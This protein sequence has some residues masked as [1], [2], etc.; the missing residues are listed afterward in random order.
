MIWYNLHSMAIR[1]AFKLRYGWRPLG[2][3]AALLEE[4]QW[5]PWS[6][7]EAL[8]MRKLKAL[9]EHA[10]AH[11]P[12]YQRRFDE[13]GVR[14]DHIQ[15]PQDLAGLPILTKRHIQEHLDELLAQGVDK[16][17][18]LESRTGGST[19]HPLTFYQDR[20][21]EAWLLADLLR[22]NRMG[23]YQL[24]MRW[25][26]LWGS[27]YDAQP[28]KGWRGFVRDRLIYNALWINTFDLT[29]DTLLHAV[30]QLVRWQP[31]II[32]AYVSSATLLARL[33]QEKGITGI[34]PQAIQTSAEVLTPEDRCLLEEA[35]AC[36]VFNRYGCREVGNIAHEC[37][38]HEGLHIL[39]DNNL[40]EVVDDAGQPAPPG[41]PGRIIVTN[42]N[43]YAMPFIRYEVGDTGALSPNTCSCGRGL[44][45]LDSV[46]GRTIDVIVAPS[47]KLIHGAFFNTLLWKLTGL[48]QFR[49][50]QETP[51]DL[52]LQLVPGPTFERQTSLAFLEETIHRYADPAFQVRFEL[53]DHLPP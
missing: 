39:A 33:I 21:H 35:F 29:K 42:L 8:Q 25:A 38:K 7:I 23:G 53:Y 19:G 16:N 14:P 50:I 20:A 27:D 15:S 36:P 3:H 26:Y 30:E 48:Y 44:P 2:R 11:V 22:S 10:Y 43:N 37:D 18:L 12:F 31:Q 40:V 46:E 24:G 6:K 5:W 47:G 32:V 17:R 9:L 52:C 41:M 28:H 4:T 45:L 51:A 34:Q 1:A 13:L 49:I